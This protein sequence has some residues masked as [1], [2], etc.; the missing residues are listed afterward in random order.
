[1]INLALKYSPQ[2]D[3]IWT[4]GS[5]VD[6]K[7]SQE[8]DLIGV[9]SIRISSPITVDLVDYTRSGTERFG[10]LT[11]MQDEIQELTMSQ[12]KSWTMSIDNANASDQLNIK[13][14]GEALQQ[15][16]EEK[17]IPFYDKHALK[18]FAINAGKS[19]VV[20]TVTKDNIVG[21]LG[22]A[23]VHFTNNNVPNSDKYLYIGATNHNLLRLSAEYLAIENMAQRSIEKGVTGNVF[24]MNVVKV[25]D[26]YMATGVQFL[27][28]H[29]RSGIA[30]KKIHTMRILTNQRGV[31][32]AV[33]EGHHYFDAFVIAKK[34][35]GVYAGVLTANKVAAPIITPTGASHAV[36]AVGGV[37]FKYTLDG[38]DP[39]YSATAIA[40]SGAVTLTS[41]QTIK[42]AGF[43]ADKCNSD[44]TSVKYTA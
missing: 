25:P 22:A 24:D 44:V 43:S 29:K 15:Q 40:Y 4:H 12:D 23:D 8:Y 28:M 33:L 27:A 13:K 1:M 17:V 6:G 7:V 32:G 10:T 41:G 34:S 5:F 31:D 26:A 11:E 2:I 9:R 3:K 14:A 18:Q 20:A 39:R 36:T 35:A 30:P 42:V 19:V 16:L 37:S 21:F 38:S